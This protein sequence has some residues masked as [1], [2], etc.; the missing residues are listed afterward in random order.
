M[1]KSNCG[2]CVTCTKLVPRRLDAYICALCEKPT[3]TGCNRPSRTPFEIGHLQAPSSSFAFLCIECKPRFPNFRKAYIL[4]GQQPI[5]NHHEIEKRCKR[6]EKQ[7]E[8]TQLQLHEYENIKGEAVTHQVLALD[9]IK[10]ELL[11]ATSPSLIRLES[12]LSELSIEQNEAKSQSDAIIERSQ[13]LEK[14]Y[15]DMLPE[16]TIEFQTIRNICENNAQQAERNKYMVPSAAAKFSGATNTPL[17]PK[18]LN[19]KR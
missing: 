12:K 7:L 2:K 8:K 9:S 5:Q 13:K 17:L 3:H 15:A 16:M 6:L 18:K 10:N 1:S 14:M 4:N 19:W 11:H